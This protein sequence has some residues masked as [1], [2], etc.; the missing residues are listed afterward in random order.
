MLQVKYGHLRRRFAW[1]KV[2][3]SICYSSAHKQYKQKKS[4]TILQKGIKKRVND[5]TYLCAATTKG[6]RLSIM[7]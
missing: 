6:P 1:E 4:A 5:V 7:P 2:H 3:S